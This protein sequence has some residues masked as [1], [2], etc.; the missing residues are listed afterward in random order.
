V[1]FA[2][3]QAFYQSDIKPAFD[4]IVAGV[5]WLVGEFKA[6]WDQIEPF[7]RP[8]FI[9]LNTLM[10]ELQAAIKVVLDLISG[11]WSGAWQGIK[12]MVQGIFDGI[13]ALGNAFKDQIVAVFTTARDAI[14]GIDWLQLGKDLLQLVIDGVVALTTAAVDAAKG[15]FTSAKDA[16]MGVDWWQVGADI[17]HWAKQGIEDMAWAIIDAAKGIAGKIGDAL[18]PKNWIGS[19]EGIQNWYP[20]YFKIGMANLAAEAETNQDLQ[21]VREIL[22]KKLDVS[23]LFAAGGGADVSGSTSAT[24]PGA[25]PPGMVWQYIGGGQYGWRPYNP[26]SIDKYGSSYQGGAGTQNYDPSLPNYQ[27][28]GIKDMPGAHYNGS[29]WVIQLQVDGKVLAEVVNKQNALGY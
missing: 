18:N 4:N 21:R 29:A 27:P 15:V 10:T 25:A 8:L 11:D 22:S 2:K 24:P 9:L 28:T 23:T 6:H 1:Q 16:I 7:V 26:L 12:D 13:V 20:Y 19:P 5:T 17:I 3:F 14:L